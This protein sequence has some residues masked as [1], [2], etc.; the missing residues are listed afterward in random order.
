MG[1]TLTRSTTI[2]GIKCD[3]YEKEGKEYRTF[4]KNNGDFMTFAED[5]D[6]FNNAP[7]EKDNSIGFYRMT[8]NDNVVLTNDNE[9]GEV[10]QDNHG[11]KRRM[12]G[13]DFPKIHH[14]GEEEK[15]FDVEHQ[16]KEGEQVVAYLELDSGIADG[17]H[18]AFVWG[19]LVCRILGAVSEQQTRDGSRCRDECAQE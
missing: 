4:K 10:D 9:Y 12:A 5:P 18:A 19:H 13:H 14:Y 11:R 8:T 1:F 2:D 3:H 15:G 17:L 6:G 7:S 16:E